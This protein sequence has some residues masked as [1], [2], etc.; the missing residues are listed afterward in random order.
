[1]TVVRLR[2]AVWL[3]LAT[4]LVFA[5]CEEFQRTIPPAASPAGHDPEAPVRSIEVPPPI[6]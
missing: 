4:S 2:S 5:G 6:R 3:L 1:M